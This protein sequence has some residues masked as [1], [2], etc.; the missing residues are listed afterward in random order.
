MTLRAG[1]LSTVTIRAYDEYNNPNVDG[2]VGAEFSARMDGTDVTI[3][4]VSGENY[5]VTF[6]SGLRASSEPI[7]IS[8]FLGVN[9][10]EGFPQEISVLPGTPLASMSTASGTGLTGG[11]AG[12]QSQIV[13]TS[14]DRYGSACD[15]GGAA[16]ALIFPSVPDSAIVPDVSFTD[17]GDGT[18]SASCELETAGTYLIQITLDED[19][20]SNMPVTRAI[21]AGEAS[22]S[23]TSLQVHN[24]SLA[25]GTVGSCTLVVRDEF[26]NRP[27]YNPSAAQAGF[28]AVATRGDGSTTFS[29]RPCSSRE[30]VGV[31]SLCVVNNLDGTFSVKFSFSQSSDH[32]VTVS[33]ASSQTRVGDG[34]TVRVSGA[35]VS[36]VTSQVVPAAADISSV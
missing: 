17:N 30:A 4:Y 5:S 28:V 14:R 8:V 25:A 6:G 36:A 26:G 19:A 7:L 32:T 2:A 3:S 20:I 33:L 24:S 12:E 18:Y 27:V 29:S 11:V 10:L 9:T 23:G 21:S 15:T 16:V 31:D 13:I 34:F 22:A 35:A 1:E